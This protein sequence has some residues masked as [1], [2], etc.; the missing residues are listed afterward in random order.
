MTSP[1]T[2]LQDSLTLTPLDNDQ[3]HVTVTLPADLFP[4]YVHLLE[5]LTGFVR[6]LLFQAHPSCRAF[7]IPPD[8]PGPSLSDLF[9]ERV[10]RRHEHGDLIKTLP[11]LVSMTG[12]K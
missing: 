7:D 2:A 1:L 11:H 9:Y 8:R 5:G 3:V 6:T 10:V 4:D 12:T